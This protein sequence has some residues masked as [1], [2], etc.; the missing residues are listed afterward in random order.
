METLHP[1]WP[2]QISR[3]LHMVLHMLLPNLRT[4]FLYTIERGHF[5]KVRPIFTILGTHIE[6]W[7]LSAERVIVRE[8]C[9]KTKGTGH[10]NGQESFEELSCNVFQHKGETVF[11]ITRDSWNWR[12]QSRCWERS[13][14]LYELAPLIKMG[15][16]LL[17]SQDPLGNPLLRDKPHDRLP[18]PKNQETCRSRHR[19]N[20]WWIGDI[21]K[22]PRLEISIDQIRI[23]PLLGQS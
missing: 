13:I 9:I 11:G 18:H 6:T 17:L 2:L 12:D 22:Y 5:I 19:P 10:V 3:Y 15:L 23:L 4:H 20:V 14:R 21:C 7:R 16:W 8:I 1:A